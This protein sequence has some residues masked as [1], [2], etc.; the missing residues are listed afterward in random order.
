MCVWGSVYVFVCICRSHSD[1]IE[2]ST[3]SPSQTWHLGLGEQLQADVQLSEVSL[4]SECLNW[5][6]TDC[7]EQAT[8]THTHIG[9]TASTHTSPLYLPLISHTDTQ[10]DGKST[11]VQRIKANE[12][13]VNDTEQQQ[14]AASIGTQSWTTEA[15]KTS[16][17]HTANETST[18]SSRVYLHGFTSSV[19]SQQCSSPGQV[20]ALQRGVM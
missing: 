1:F 14:A 8:H 16:Y 18:W 15:F 5:I 7:T 13:R 12:L 3:V 20:K 11:L 19:R 9:N 2:I 10:S 4:I 17:N 6:S